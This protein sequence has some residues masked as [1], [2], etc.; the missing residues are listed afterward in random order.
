[1]KDPPYELVVFIQVL[2]FLKELGI[3]AAEC[4]KIVDPANL[5]DCNQLKIHCTHNR[6]CHF[7]EIIFRL[8][9]GSN[10]NICGTCPSE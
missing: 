4:H 6:Y 2:Y 1:M 8:G 5:I 3:V 9:Q 7:S 10:R